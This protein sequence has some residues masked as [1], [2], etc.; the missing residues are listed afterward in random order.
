MREEGVCAILAIAVLLGVLSWLAVFI[1]QRQRP[2]QTAV[3]RDDMQV[4]V[5]T[6]AELGFRKQEAE[7]LVQ[8]ALEAAPD[9]DYEVLI[10]IAIQQWQPTSRE[11]RDP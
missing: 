2:Q 5:E 4:A 3:D 9:G 10:N 6:L 1:E 7:K 8:K 11:S